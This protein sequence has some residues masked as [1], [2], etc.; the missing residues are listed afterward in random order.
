MKLFLKR[1]WLVLKL[2]FPLAFKYWWK[3]FKNEWK[4]LNI[5]K[6]KKEIKEKEDNGKN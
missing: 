6:I 2:S 4:Q 3:A 1:V 5:D